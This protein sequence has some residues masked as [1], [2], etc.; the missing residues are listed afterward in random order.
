MQQYIIIYD[1]PNGQQSIMINACQ[2]DN[3]KKVIK[4]FFGD[5]SINTISSI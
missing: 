4:D 5:Y 1:T 3:A 2:L